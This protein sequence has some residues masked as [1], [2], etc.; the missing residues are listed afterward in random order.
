MHCA[1]NKAKVDFKDERGAGPHR[2][3]LG[4]VE[5]VAFLELTVAITP[6]N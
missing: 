3:G 1:R 4:P 2:S 5:T 6:A